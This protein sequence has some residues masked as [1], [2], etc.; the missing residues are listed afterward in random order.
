MAGWL[1]RGTLPF[2][3]FAMVNMAVVLISTTHAASSS[4]FEIQF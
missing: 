4:G 2:V 3:A 1:V